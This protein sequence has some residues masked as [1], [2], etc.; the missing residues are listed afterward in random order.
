MREFTMKDPA[1]DTSN[2]QHFKKA[3]KTIPIYQT[4]IEYLIEKG[5]KTEW[6]CPNI[7][8]IVLFQVFLKVSESF[9]RKDDLFRKK[10]RS[11]EKAY[12]SMIDIVSGNPLSFT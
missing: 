7:V 3:I 9:I 12:N 11:I 1:F 5:Y 2:D 4:K 10:M 6:G 8:H